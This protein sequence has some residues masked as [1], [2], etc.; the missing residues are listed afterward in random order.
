MTI[1]MDGES[2]SIAQKKRESH[3]D[4]HN[5]VTFTDHPDPVGETPQQK[6]QRGLQ[7]LRAMRDDDPGVGK[8][9]LNIRMDGDNFSIA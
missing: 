6:T 9:G 7:I 8:L 4:E 5:Y 3:I 2:L 1:R